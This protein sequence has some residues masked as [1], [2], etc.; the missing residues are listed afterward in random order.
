MDFGGVFGDTCW[1]TNAIATESGSH[2]TWQP[3][4]RAAI[5]QLLSL[6]A[7]EALPDLRSRIAE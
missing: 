1:N 4:V 3:G 7:E 5:A 6:S 2:G